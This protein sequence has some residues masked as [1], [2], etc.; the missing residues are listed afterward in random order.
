MVIKILDFYIFNS[1]ASMLHVTNL[2]RLIITNIF[3]TSVY[4]NLYQENLT[5]KNSLC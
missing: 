5:F 4:K 3:R 2:R 1:T